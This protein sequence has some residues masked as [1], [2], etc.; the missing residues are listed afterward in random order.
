MNSL[1]DYESIEPR[2]E[3]TEAVDLSYWE[4]LSESVQPELQPTHSPYAY[5][6]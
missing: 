3:G 4:T 6:E 5:T 1:F 2:G